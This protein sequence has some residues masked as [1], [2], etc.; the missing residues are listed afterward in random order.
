M[1]KNIKIKKIIKW[2]SIISLFV[3]FGMIMYLLSLDQIGTNPDQSRLEKRA[4]SSHYKDGKFL[5]IEETSMMKLNFFKA[6]YK[7][8]TEKHPDSEPKEELPYIKL[9]QSD[10]SEKPSDKFSAT[11]LGHSSMLIEIEGKRYVTDPM[12][13][14]HYSPIKFLAPKRFYPAPVKVEDLPKLDGVIISHNHYDHLDYGTILEFAKTDVKFFVALGIAETLIDWGIDSSRII[15]KT[16]WESYT[17]GNIEL[18]NTPSRHFSGRKLI[19]KDKTQWSS[20]VIKGEKYSIFFG[21]DGGPSEVFQEIGDKYGPF[22]LA[23][24]EIGASS[25]DWP[26]IHMGPENALETLRKLR[27]T[28]FIPIHWGTFDLALHSWYD[29][30]VRLTKAAKNTDIKIR[31]PLPGET[32][33]H[34]EFDKVDDWWAKICGFEM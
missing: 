20:W 21:G 23:F 30:V 10:F 17:D 5:N 6:G 26:D 32:V 31:I 1:K 25:E 27:C 33:K 13:S 19:D 12:Y 4:D 14:D 9:S 8:L 7:F 18:I 29:P 3:I 28:H 2:F 34:H 11:W 15:E 24:I 16:W 22:E